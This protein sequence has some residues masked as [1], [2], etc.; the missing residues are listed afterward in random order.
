MGNLFE[1]SYGRNGGNTLTVIGFAAQAELT[2]HEERALA[3]KEASFTAED[4]PDEGPTPE[5]S[6][7]LAEA[8]EEIERIRQQ[9]VCTLEQRE[10][11]VADL[12]KHKV[13]FSPGGL[14]MRERTE[15][16]YVVTSSFGLA[17]RF[18]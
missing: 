10:S 5:W 18:C 4:K 11:A 6:S 7:Q 9:L 2:Q 13:S 1:R 12:N 8:Q 3:K 16:T 17:S 15:Y 14:G